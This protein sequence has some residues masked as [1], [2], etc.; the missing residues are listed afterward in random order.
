MNRYANLLAAASKPWAIHEHGMLAV[1]AIVEDV[2]SG[3]PPTKYA[4][5]A[6]TPDPYVDRGV[7]VVPVRGVLMRR[8]NLFTRSSGAT[9]YESL[10]REIRGH[11]GP[12]VLDIDSVG[13]SVAGISQVLKAIERHP[14]PIYAVAN[15]MAASAAYWIASGADRVFVTPDAEV[16]SIG[17]FAAR[18]DQ[19]ERLEREGLKHHVWRSVPRKARSL[20][21]QPLTD[22]EDEG[23]RTMVERSHARF[24]AHVAH[25]RNLTMDNINFDGRT[26]GAEE[27]VSE[28]LADAVG[29]VEDA[30]EL[31]AIRQRVDELEAENVALRQELH[32]MRAEREADRL[33]AEGRVP[34]ATD[35][36][37]LIDRLVADF[38]GTLAVLSLV[39]SGSFAPATV[40]F[41]PPSVPEGALIAE[42]DEEEEVFR[43]LGLTYVRP[44]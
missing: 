27:A 23:M 18:W 4:V 12:I 13:G 40:S 28:G 10:A 22:I 35:R 31:L 14:H 44:A 33:I 43:A 26:L 20:E 19:S 38:D 36:D 11:D 32:R 29:S 3:T 9:S 2:L 42:A 39:P 25:N 17:V 30:V 8:G 7:K 1:C 16:G 24:V 5:E 41:A 6:E 34:A 37:A 15:D 21:S